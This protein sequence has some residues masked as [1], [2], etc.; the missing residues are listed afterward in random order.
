MEHAERRLNEQPEITV[1]DVRSN[2]LCTSFNN[3]LMN[4]Q[5]S[6]IKENKIHTAVH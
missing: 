5:F 2:T 4:W 1:K 6:R 3:I